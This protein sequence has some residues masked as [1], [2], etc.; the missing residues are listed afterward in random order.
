M[1]NLGKHIAFFMTLPRHFESIPE[2]SAFYDTSN[3]TV[4]ATSLAKDAAGYNYH[5][6]GGLVHN[7]NDGI[8][9]VFSYEGNASKSYRTEKFASFYS[10]E[11]SANVTRV[12]VLPEF[13][14][15][16][17]QRLESKN[18]SVGLVNNCPDVG[19]NLNLTISGNNYKAA[20]CY[21]PYG[22]VFF[23]VL[24]S[25]APG[26]DLVVSGKVVNGVGFN[27]VGSREIKPID[28]RGFIRVTINDPVETET[29]YNNGVP[30]DNRNYGLYL[31]P[32]P[33]GLS[34]SY[35]V[36]HT[37]IIQKADVLALNFFGGIYTIGLWG[38]DIE[39]MISKDMYPP[40]HQYDIDDLEY[41]LFARKTFNKDLTYYEGNTSNFAEVNKL[42]VNWRFKFT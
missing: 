37:L 1:D 25:L 14:N 39:K 42:I 31:R 15:P 34:P 22:D 36:W 24:S 23:Y 30:L 7:P 38:Y 5:A 27:S 29:K 28:T 11:V 40:Y 18:T 20:G 4:R 32:N 21:A 19:H 13:S 9:R 35:E 16:Y 6:H 8:F 41:K 12:K 26:A 3:Y 17:M 2:A 33:A 10:P